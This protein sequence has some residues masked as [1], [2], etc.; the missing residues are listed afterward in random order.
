[1]EGSLGRHRHR[2]VGDPRVRGNGFWAHLG[3]GTG[4]V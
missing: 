2:W 3:H 4:K 1:M